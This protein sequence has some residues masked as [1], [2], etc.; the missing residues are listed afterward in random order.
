MPDDFDTEPRRRG[1]PRGTQIAIIDKSH[2]FRRRRAAVER[3]EDDD[4]TEKGT[5]C[6]Q[7]CHLGHFLVARMFRRSRDSAIIYALGYREPGGAPF[8][9]LVVYSGARGVTRAR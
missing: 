2:W 4:R 1:V 5:E 3:P 8:F 9:A 6:R 7:E